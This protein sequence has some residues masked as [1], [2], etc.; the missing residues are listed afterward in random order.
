MICIIEMWQSRCNHVLLTLSLIISNILEQYI[1]RT[2]KILNFHPNNFT[3]GIIGLNNLKYRKDN[4]HVIV[5]H[6]IAYI[7]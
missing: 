3:F 7:F 5:Y 4:V 1:L 6:S 2:L